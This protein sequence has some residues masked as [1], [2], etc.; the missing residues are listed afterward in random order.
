MK[1][2]IFFITCLLLY[3]AISGS[4]CTHTG[5]VDCANGVCF[6]IDTFANNIDKSLKNHCMG[7]GYA[8]YYKDTIQRF[9][10]GGFKRTAA[11]GG[12]ELF[13]GF[14][15][16]HIA[17]MSK[18][19]T[20]IAT[21]QLLS[22]N[23]LNTSIKIKD[24]LPPDWVI[25]PNIDKITFR[26][27]MRHEAGI[28]DTRVAGRNGDS[29][30]ALRNKIQDGVIA[31]SIGVGQYQNM[32]YSLLRVIIPKLAGFPHL[33][34]N[35]DTST[36]YKYIRYVQQNIFKPC[37]VINGG[38]CFPQKSDSFYYYQWPY[39]NQKGTLL[40]DY[41]LGSGAFGWYLSVSDYGGIIDKLFNSQILLS[42]NWRDTMTTNYLGCGSIQGIK[43]NYFNNGGWEWGDANG[44]G[45]MN[46]CWIYFPND[47][48]IVVM[49]NSDVPPNMF[50]W[51]I[52]P[53]YD[54]AWR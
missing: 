50:P 6:Y 39:N 32:D 17:S 10:S 48:I 49:A 23:N 54:N 40:T 22:K 35:N 27:L 7:Y 44:S 11:D 4:D 16:I 30:D 21:M 31:D 14:D 41:S 29:Y 34:Q 15:K 19:I 52:G 53:L 33:T 9:H 20:A 51:G 28:R 1:T 47:I 5:G 37:N 13:S 12:Q 42:N 2:R 36:A 46:A 45:A 3:F 18:T 38:N 24:Y 8:I 25:G 43:G 26:M